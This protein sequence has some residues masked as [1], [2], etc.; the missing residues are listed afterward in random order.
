MRSENHNPE[1]LIAFNFVNLII[2]LS[3]NIEKPICSGGSMIVE[4]NLFHFIGG[5]S[6]KAFMSEDHQLVQ[7]ARL[8]GVKARFMDN[9]MVKPSLRRL[10]KEGKLQVLYKYL[11][12]TIHFFLNGKVDKKIIEYEMGGQL[13]NRKE[14]RWGMDA[15]FNY[16]LTQIKD[17]IR[18]IFS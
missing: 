4:K 9:I 8:H 3:Q 12:I 6:E 13:Y 15:L 18:N 10:T 2:G 11:I 1:T 17:F 16:S 7:K 5:F 14:K